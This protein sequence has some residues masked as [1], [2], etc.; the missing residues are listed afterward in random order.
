MAIKHLYLLSITITKRPIAGFKSIYRITTVLPI[1]LKK[2]NESWYTISLKKRYN[3]NTIKL[4][5]LLMNFLNIHGWCLKSK[6]DRQIVPLF[7]KARVYYKN[8]ANSLW[9]LIWGYKTKFRVFFIVISII[10]CNIL[11]I[12]EC[13]VWVQYPIFLK[14]RGLVCSS[15][16]DKKK[17]KKS[18]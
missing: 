7:R 14:L 8:I 6:I 11:T 16:F 4:I 2:N 13:F 18:L 3:Y 1:F 12:Y 17:K 9:W 5:V 15:V 10:V